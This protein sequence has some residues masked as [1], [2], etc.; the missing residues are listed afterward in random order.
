MNNRR[1][2]QRYFTPNGA[3]SVF[4]ES[5]DD[6]KTKKT[7]DP[8]KNNTDAPDATDDDLQNVDKSKGG[9]GGGSGFSPDRT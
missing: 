9:Y 6:D 7:Q 8:D 5:T 1:T 2:S 3:S 4:A